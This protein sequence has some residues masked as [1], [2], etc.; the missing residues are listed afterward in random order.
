MASLVAAHGIVFLESSTMF[1][2]ILL[3]SARCGQCEANPQRTDEDKCHVAGQTTH[4]MTLLLVEKSFQVY[5]SLK[6]NLHCCFSAE[7]K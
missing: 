7:G 4:F 1:V 2:H 3:T 6:L 5:P